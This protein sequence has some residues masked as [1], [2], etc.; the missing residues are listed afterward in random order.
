[1]SGTATGAGVG[2]GNG[3]DVGGTEVAVG[4]CVAVSV[5]AGTVKVAEGAEGAAQAERRIKLIR[6]DKKW[7]RIFPPEYLH[8]P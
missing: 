4:I 8:F 2:V 3:V 7:L 1:M 6:R 5:G